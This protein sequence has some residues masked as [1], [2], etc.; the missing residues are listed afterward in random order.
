MYSTRQM[1]A[2][3][4][5]Q[6]YENRV[7]RSSSSNCPQP[8]SLPE[9]RGRLHTA[10]DQRIYRRPNLENSRFIHRL[11]PDVS[12]EEDECA[13]PADMIFV[14]RMFFYGSFTLQS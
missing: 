12:S 5:H 4:P 8:L 2:T 6:P 9:R 7:R 13:C 11:L 14:N 10:S 1:P 3:N